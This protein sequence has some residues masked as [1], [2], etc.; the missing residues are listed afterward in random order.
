MHSLEQLNIYSNVSIVTGDERPPSITTTPAN[1]S[2]LTSTVY[3]TEDTSHN[4]VVPFTIDSA[5]SIDIIY[6]VNVS[7]YSGATVTW[8][9]Q[10][11]SLTYTNPSTGIYRVSGIGSITQWNAQKSPLVF[12]GPDRNGNLTYRANISGVGS[13]ISWNNNA[14][15]AAT[16]EINT[17]ILPDQ[18]YDEDTPITFNCGLLITDTISSSYSVAISKSNNAAGVLSSTGVGGT[19][20]Y[21]ANV[22]TIA[23]T[24]TQVNSRLGNITLTPGEGFANDFALTYNVLNVTSGEPNSAQQAMKIRFITDEINTTTLTNQTYNQDDPITFD[25]GLIITNASTVAT[26]SLT[27]SKPSNATG[28]MYSTGVGGTSSYANNTLTITGNKGQINTRL[29]A[30]T[31]VPTAGPYTNFTLT[32]TLTN[33]LSGQ[34]EV[35]THTMT[36]DY[37]NNNVS[38][39]NV[40]RTYTQN[41]KNTLFATNVPTITEDIRRPTAPFVA[42][43]YTALLLHFD[44]NITDSSNNAYTPQIINNPT[45]F[46]S[47]YR[48]WGTASANFTTIQ[49]NGDGA[50]LRFIDDGVKN[51]SSAFTAECWVNP[52]S[53]PARG[54]FLLGP[55]QVSTGLTSTNQLR[56]VFPVVPNGPNG[57]SPQ[58]PTYIGP[59]IERNKFTHI[60][61]TYNNGTWYVHVNGTMRHTVYQLISGPEPYWNGVFVTS[62]A[63][64]GIDEFRYSKGIA[65]Y[66]NSNFAVSSYTIPQYSFSLQLSTNIGFISTNNYEGYYN[67]L[68]YNST[69]RTYTFTGYRDECNSMLADLQFYPIRNTTSSAVITYSQSKNGVFQFNT[70]FDLTGIVNTNSIPGTGLT[71]YST[72]GTTNFVPT[73]EQLY[74][75]R[76]DLLMVGPGGRAG[77]TNTI[78]SPGPSGSISTIYRGG[79]G[80]GGEIKTVSNI[81]L[82]N[83]YNSTL[84]SIP[85]IIPAGGSE[86]AT[87]FGLL[88]ANPGGN[89]ASG[90]RNG[91]GDGG[92]SAYPGGQ[93]TFM[94]G[95]HWGGGG[96]GAGGPGGNGGGPSGGQNAVGGIGL[97]VTFNGI[98]E[99]YSRGGNP[100]DQFL[101]AEPTAKPGNGEVGPGLIIIKF[102]E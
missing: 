81:I 16:A 35:A 101:S 74:T 55:Y 62:G 34:V 49:Q 80:G 48:Q 99:T 40:S 32:Y 86:T 3:S 93:G 87:S 46:D 24:R 2:N 66:S 39:M 61:V 13:T 18:D 71:T 65:R 95:Y 47:A 63:A 53:G 91:A 1:T 9:T 42:D 15:L 56:V 67:K 36:L 94:D 5:I 89:G 14:I 25:S 60:A 98:T 45:N 17:G 97:S 26:Y 20:T 10:D 21:T 100:Q 7:M 11:L 23:G 82:V 30:I 68:N 41:I 54:L 96:G 59:I 12:M 8:P 85:V 78:L 51:N 64:G 4:L 79:G 73:F 27:I 33:L 44:S 69:T 84:S 43:A 83:N 58:T 50:G 57:T 102:Y 75:L 37:L 29:T 6:T 70:T 22:L 19:S 31:F 76:A 77:T 28:V 88:T 72:V 38:N 92:A 90:D 52:N